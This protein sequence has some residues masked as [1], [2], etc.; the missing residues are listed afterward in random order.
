MQLYRRRCNRGTAQSTSG[1][2]NV[3]WTGPVGAPEQGPPEYNLIGCHFDEANC[4]S[5]MYRRCTHRSGGIVDKDAL[6]GPETCSVAHDECGSRS[7]F[8]AL[9]HIHETI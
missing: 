8:A 2:L 9:P 7:D 3:E 5:G 4:T 6:G 1:R